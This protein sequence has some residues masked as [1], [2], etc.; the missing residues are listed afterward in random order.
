MT[1]QLVGVMEEVDSQTLAALVVLLGACRSGSAMTLLTH[2]RPRAKVFRVISPSG[3]P[4]GVNA[5]GIRPTQLSSASAYLGI[6]TLRGI[7]ALSE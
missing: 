6:S 7:S 1:L 2:M 3:L 4:P 5:N